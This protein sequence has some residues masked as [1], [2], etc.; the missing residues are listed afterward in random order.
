MLL[1]MHSPLRSVLACMSWLF[2]FNNTIGLNL[3]DDE[4]YKVNDEQIWHKVSAEL[5]NV[6]LK[7]LNKTIE[8]SQAPVPTVLGR[9]GVFARKL[10]INNKN[11]L[12]SRWY[13]LINAN[14][15][16]KGLG[17][18]VPDNGLPQPL[19]S[20]SQLA[21]KQTPH[22]LHYQAVSLPIKPGQSGD[23]WLLV[24]AQ[25]FAYPLSLQVLSETQFYRKQFLINSI[26]VAAVAIML[27]LGVIAFILFLR[28]RYVLAIACAGYVGLH[29]LGWAAASGLI[30]DFFNLTWGNTTYGG[31]LLFPFAIA[32]AA[33]FTRLLFNCEATAPKTS[34]LLSVFAWVSLLCG[35]LGPF[36]ALHEIFILSHILASIWL[37]IT[38]FVGIR[39][40]GKS[41]FRARYYLMG[42]AVYACSLAYYMY[43]HMSDSPTA[44]YPELVVVLALSIDCICI[45]LSLGEWI[46][47]SQTEY[48]RSYIQARFDSLTKVGNRFSFNES[49]KHLHTETII[50]FLDLDGMKGINDRLGHDEGDRFLCESAMYMEKYLEG[51]AKVFRAGGDEFIWLVNGSIFVNY[52]LCILE[53][54]KIVER[55]EQKLAASGWHSVGI[56]IGMASTAES[57]T[58]SACL[59]LA[60][61]RMYEHKRQKNK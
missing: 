42:N 38:L 49:I 28:T 22:I 30:D 3:T 16:D 39:M 11:L 46:K 44:L 10:H 8:N 58:I 27:V 43:S 13:L 45:L 26:T 47:N 32:C 31:M 59:A 12:G 35:I 7:F 4:H 56:S 5:S 21:D 61:K 6:D 1:N 2:A 40:L 34:K 37:P 33:F 53:L 15:I 51:K 19:A 41:D 50:A 54:E 24:S 14:F 29:G 18:W 25:H 55:I 52:D 23:L 60:D 20:F 17:Y 57:P 48:K 9:H 36:I